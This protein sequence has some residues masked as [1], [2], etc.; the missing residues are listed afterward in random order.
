MAKKKPKR[1][2]T[3]APKKP[4]PPKVPDELKS[5]VEAKAKGLIEE[6]LNPTY[7]KLPPED[8]R[9]NYLTG[10]STK[11]HHSFFYLVGEYAC[12]GPDALAPTFESSFARMEYV[13]DGRFNLAYFRHTGKWWEVHRD[14]TLDESIETIRDHGIFHPH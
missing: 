7:V 1:V 10:I 9:W 5:E 4:T 2:W 12:P 13:G 14:L 3:Y 6:G 11:W 8:Q